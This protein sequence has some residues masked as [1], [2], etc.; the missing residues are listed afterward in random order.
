MSTVLDQALAS[1]PL[2]GAEQ[3]IKEPTDPWTDD[4]ACKIAVQDFLAAERYR[5]QNHDWR[6]RVSDELYLAWVAQKYWEGTKIPRASIPVFLAF[7]QVESLLPKLMSAIFSDNPWFDGEPGLGVAVEIM[8][9]FR[10]KVRN[11]LDDAQVRETFRRAIK[12]ALIYGNGI[13]ELSW[14][15]QKNKSLKYVPTWKFPQQQQGNVVNFAKAKRVLEKRETEEIENRPV[16]SNISIKDFYFDPNATSPV[17]QDPSHGYVCIRV[18]KTIQFLDSLRENKEFTIPSKDE[19]AKMAQQRPSAQSDTT[20]SV[21]ELMRFGYWAPQNDQTSDPAGK[22][23]ELISRVSKDRVVWVLNRTKTILNKPNPYGFINYYD[24][25]YADVPDRAYGMSMCD[26]L[27]GEQRF[28]TSLINARVDELALSIHA[29]VQ[30]KRGL[31]IPSYQLRTRPGQ[32]IQVET[33]GEDYVRTEMG[34]IT[35]NAYIEDQASEARAQKITGLS[36][37]IANGMGQEGGNSA[38]RTATGIGAQ[39][40]AGS[41]RIQGLLETLEDTYIEPILNDT[42]KLNILFPPLGTNAAQIQQLQNVKLYMR[43]SARMK[44]QMTLLQTLPLV[45]QSILNPALI[46]QMGQQGIGLNWKEI[47]TM[48]LDT[49]GFQNRA[50]LIRKLTPQEIQQMQQQMQAE[51]QLKMQMQQQRLQSQQQQTD[52]KLQHSTQLEQMKLDGKHD[53]EETK[54]KHALAAALIPTMIEHALAGSTS[55]E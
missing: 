32:M 52:A 27:E 41:S 34:G 15:S 31:N 8:R 40:Q 47:M 26:V 18:Y 39:V 5:S 45:L 9:Q 25:F 29:P 36:D 17:I 38:S 55:S 12:S 13:T 2:T 35:Q 19:L 48:I 20:K 10:D 11:Q 22:R 30:Y 54:G 51:A 4:M 16:L 7:Q 42:V 21:V 43:A 3:Q 24:A 49:T 23:I 6:Y 33:P 44:S 1:M 50:D 53:I 28:K 37:L 46:T 14:V